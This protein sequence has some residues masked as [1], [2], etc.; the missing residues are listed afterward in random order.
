MNRTPGTVLFVDVKWVFQ[1]VFWQNRGAGN[2]PIIY[3]YTAS[4]ELRDNCPRQ[5]FC[6]EICNHPSS[7]LSEL[8]KL[9]LM[10]HNGFLMTVLFFKPTV[11]KFQSLVLAS[12]GKSL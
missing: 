4:P 12:P 3:K 1:V 2:S 10:R 7:T 6:L 8:K 11:C 9:S 5:F